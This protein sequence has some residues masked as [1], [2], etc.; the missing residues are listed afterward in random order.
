LKVRLLTTIACYDMRRVL[1][2]ILAILLIIVGLLA[3]ITPLTPGSW[4]AL[5]GLEILGIR[6]LVQRKFLSFLPRKYH[7]KVRS[8]LKVKKKERSE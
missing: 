7:R 2:I 1:R 4:L 3:L 6:I 5:I 8:I